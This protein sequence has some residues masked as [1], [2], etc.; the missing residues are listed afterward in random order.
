MFRFPSWVFIFLFGSSVCF[1]QDNPGYAYKNI[2]AALLTHANTV[3]RTYETQIDIASPEEVYVKEH[4]VL[5]VLNE[6]GN[7]DAD[8][9]EYFSSLN[10]IESI[11]GCLYDANGEKIKK[12]K[13]SDFIELPASMHA[14]E[15]S[16]AKFKA[17]HVNYGQYPYTIEYTIETKQNHSFYFPYWIPQAN[18]QCAVESAV[19]QVTVQNG[20]TLKYKGFNI[21]D[22]PAISQESGKKYQWTLKGIAAAKKEPMRFTG[23]YSTPVIILAVNDFVLDSFK[24]STDSWKDFGDFVYRLNKGRDELPQEVKTRIQQL[25]AGIS[26]DREK[27]RI[28]YGYMQSIMRYVSVTYGIGGWQTLDAEFLSKNQYGDCKALSN[29]MMA[30]LSEAGIRSYPVLITAGNENPH[31]LCTDFV[32][33]QFNHCILCVPSARDTTWLECTSSDL[34]ADYLSDFTQDRD[35]LM[36]TPNGG[37]LVHTPKYDTTVNLVVRHASITC[38]TDGSLNINMSSVYTGEGASRLYGVLKHYNDHDREEFL[39]WKFRLE[40]YTLNDYKYERMEQAPVLCLRENALLTATGLLTKT[41]NRTFITLNIDPISLTDRG[42]D[43]NRKDPFHIPESN[44]ATDTFDITLPPNTEVEFIPPPVAV[45]H[46]FGSY[47]YSITQGGNKLLVICKFTLN[48]GTYPAA[49]YSDYI[50]FADLVENN[51]H[52]K[53]VLRTKQ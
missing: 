45:H 27:I 43:E 35:A 23:V 1:G 39:H 25:I 48:S 46:P 16:D 21:S 19:L 5:T 20:I 29:Y 8:H 42:E 37:F 3:M 51:S 32:C 24:G 31:V 4:Y 33:S 52:K 6:K 15:F 11:S 13:Q 36:I 41:G 49:L 22:G 17:Y 30:M 26:D 50:K 47:T 34:P 53:V 2:P 38:N 44:A 12:I 10:R 28:L 18:R 40:S 14:G 7:S 9:A